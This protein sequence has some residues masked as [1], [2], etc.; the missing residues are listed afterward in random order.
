MPHE[1]IS[2]LATLTLSILVL[3]TVTF[4]TQQYVFTLQDNLA[5]D[6]L[7]DITDEIAS[8]VIEL[9]KIGRRS[10]DPAATEPPRTVATTRIELL[11]RVVGNSFYRILPW[12]GREVVGVLLR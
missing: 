12:P 11:E 2:T 3:S 9:Y 8:H 10:G 4:T 7:Q 6:E 5:E 1:W